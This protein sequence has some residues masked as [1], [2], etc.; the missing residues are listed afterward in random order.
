[1]TNIKHDLKRYLSDSKSEKWLHRILTHLL[2]IPDANVRLKRFETV[3][4]E[5]ELALMQLLVPCLER[6]MRG[7]PM[8]EEEYAAL[9]KQVKESKTAKRVNRLHDT[10]AEQLLSNKNPELFFLAY[11]RSRGEDVLTKGLDSDGDLKSQMVWLMGRG[12][13]KFQ[14]AFLRQVGVSCDKALSFALSIISTWEGDLRHGPVRPDQLENNH[15]VELM[16]GALGFLQDS[17]NEAPLLQEGELGEEVVNLKQ[18]QKAWLERIIEALPTSYAAEEILSSLLHIAAFV[19]HQPW[20]EAFDDYDDHPEEACS[21]PGFLRAKEELPEKDLEVLRERAAYTFQ[22]CLRIQEP[23]ATKF[24]EW[25]DR[26]REQMLK[27]RE[28]GERTINWFKENSHE[29]EQQFDRRTQ[30]ILGKTLRTLRPN[31]EDSVEVGVTAL[32]NAGIRG[33]VFRPEGYTFPDTRVDIVVRQE[34][35]TLITF[36]TELRNLELKVHPEIV[37]RGEHAD[38]VE[39]LAAL[40]EYTVVDAYFR[41]IAANSI[42]R[43]RHS[44]HK[45]GQDGQ[46]VTREVNVRSFPR[47]L[48]IGQKAGE[49]ARKAYYESFGRDLPPGMTFVKGF[50]RAQVIE[51]A[52]P[53]ASVTYKDLDLLNA[54]EWS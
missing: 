11:S 30:A 41:I 32:R 53:A 17:I 50:I 5:L 14:E 44:W 24:R 48:R 33:F 10:I 9:V 25:R 16:S 28:T 45:T 31:G 18:A 38:E 42:V 39:T 36:R 29:I 49:E 15:S 8:S 40:L 27:K 2:E 46:N 12:L 35:P 20:Y 34:T 13:F 52:H 22:P 23:F 21:H 54:A 6:E 4:I 43:E 3:C 37:I 51:Y 26:H 19:L 47:R 1:M 7:N